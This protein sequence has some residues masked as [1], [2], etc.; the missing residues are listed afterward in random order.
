VPNVGN[1]RGASAER[2][3]RPG[4]PDSDHPTPLAIDGS[5]RIVM[6]AEHPFLRLRDSQPAEPC[7]R[8]H[9]VS[10]G[11]SWSLFCAAMGGRLHTRN[12]DKVKSYA[13][14]WFLRPLPGLEPVL[15]GREHPLFPVALKHCG[16]NVAETRGRLPKI[17]ANIGL[18]NGRSFP[19]LCILRIASS[20]S[21]PRAHK[22]IQPPVGWRCTD[23][24]PADFRS[25]MFVH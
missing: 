15:S 2:R 18:A 1:G 7:P 6:N 11:G 22:K 21:L 13:D 14:R 9:E 24:S 3:V 25:H 23:G 16:A 19:V 20:Y 10:T 4:D 17:S 5:E 8:L 12:K